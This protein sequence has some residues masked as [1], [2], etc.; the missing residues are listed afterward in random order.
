M[1]EEYY[2][3]LPGGFVL[4]LAL[5]V[6]RYALADTTPREIVREEAEALL[7]DFALA[8]LKHIMIAGTLDQADTALNSKPGI[9]H[10][11]GEYRCTE[12]IGIRQRHQIG[13]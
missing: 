11:A 7:R 10:L 12:L 9:W 13:E 2:I 6:E 1:Y 3:T 8:Y 4:P 5:T